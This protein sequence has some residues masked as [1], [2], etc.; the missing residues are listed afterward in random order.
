LLGTN[1]A[2]QV[3]VQVELEALNAPEPID[4]LNDSWVRW[5]GSFLGAAEDWDEFLKSAEFAAW[6]D[7]MRDG[8]DPCDDFER[9]LI[10]TDADNLFAGTAWMPSYLTKAVR[11]VIGCDAFPDDLDNLAAIY[12]K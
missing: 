8:A 3:D 2:L 4:D 11:A 1:V 10:D 6:G 7:T 5:H 12:G 9:E